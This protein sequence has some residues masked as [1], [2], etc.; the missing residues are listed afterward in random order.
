MMRRPAYWFVG[1]RQLIPWFRTLA[2]TISTS[3]YCILS[4]SSPGMRLMTHFSP[5]ASCI[6]ARAFSLSKLKAALRHSASLCA[7]ASHCEAEGHQFPPASRRSPRTGIE[8]GLGAANQAFLN[9][10]WLRPPEPCSEAC[11]AHFPFFF[12]LGDFAFVLCAMP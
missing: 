4:V 10:S 12:F 8:S 9:L 7:E 3:N 11:N 6:S 5:L 1:G 2:R